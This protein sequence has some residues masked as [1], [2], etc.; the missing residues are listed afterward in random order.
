MSSIIAMK[1]I[2]EANRSRSIQYVLEH[3]VKSGFSVL[4][5]RQCEMTKAY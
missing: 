3:Q 1:Y 5:V 2:Y 4:T